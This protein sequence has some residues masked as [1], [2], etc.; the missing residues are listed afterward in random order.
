[1]LLEDARDVGAGCDG[2]PRIGSSPTDQGLWDLEPNKSNLICQPWMSR[3]QEVVV[4]RR[5]GT[6][7]SRSLRDLAAVLLM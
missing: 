3:P 5:N 1:M 4:S 2:Q 6:S 7:E